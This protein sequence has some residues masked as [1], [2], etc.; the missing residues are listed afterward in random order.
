MIRVLL[1]DDNA[2]V[3]RALG[4]R[5][6]P[7]PDIMIQAPGATSG[8]DA[9]RL[10]L[11]TSPDVVVMNMRP[12]PRD[13]ISATRKLTALPVRLR[14]VLFATSH[15]D[16]YVIGGLADGARGIVHEDGHPSEVIC[17]IRAAH[18]GDMVISP[19]LTERLVRAIPLDR[20]VRQP[21]AGN[22]LSAREREVLRALCDSPSTDAAIATRLHIETT[23][24]KGHLKRIKAKAGATRR[25]ELVAWAF[26]NGYVR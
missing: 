24:V 23:S 12:P 7:E 15:L 4:I 13:G 6:A 18:R 10:A 8:D 11:A 19:R 5:L 20:R 14:V 3:R 17:A 26:R 16:Q 25:A 22:L 21:R 1:A 9:V 2:D